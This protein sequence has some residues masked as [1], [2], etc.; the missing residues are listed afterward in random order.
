MTTHAHHPLCIGHDTRQGNPIGA[1]DFCARYGECRRNRDIVRG[2]FDD[3]TA[4]RHRVCQKG[5]FDAFVADSDTMDSSPEQ[6]E[7][8]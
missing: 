3:T 7:Q 8:L 4:I 1:P 5:K 6:L 2:L